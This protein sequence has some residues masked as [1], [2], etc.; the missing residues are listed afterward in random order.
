MDFYM[1]NHPLLPLDE[2]YT[3]KVDKVSDVFLD[4]FVSILLR[5][6]CIMFIKQMSETFSLLSL[7]VV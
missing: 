6:F 2:A 1:L 5:F 7:C 3:I 4:C